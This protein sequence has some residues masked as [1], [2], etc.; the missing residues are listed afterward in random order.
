MEELEL[1]APSNIADYL[2]TMP[3]LV[4][5]ASTT[6]GNNA[7]S[8]GN[9]GMSLL[10]LR[11][12]GASRT[13]VL[14]DGRRHV[15]STL[16]GNVDANTLP[17]GLIE[18]VEVVTG[19]ASSVYGS[20]A[21]AGVV[22][23]KLN[24]DYVGT[25][26]FIQGG[27]SRYHDDN[28]VTTG[29]TLGRGFAQDRGHF[30]MD[31]EY[32]HS[33]GVENA[34]RRS[35]WKGWGTITNTDTLHSDNA[36][37]RIT[38][39]YENRA[40]EAPGGV[41]T[42]GPLKWTT[43]DPDGSPRLFDPGRL[44]RGGV[45]SSGGELDGHYA[46]MSLK[47][48]IERHNVFARG[49]FELTNA[50]EIFAEGTHAQSVVNTNSSYNYYNGNLTIHSDNPYLDPAVRDQMNAAGETSADYGLLLGVASPRVKVKTNRAV[51]GVN[52]RVGPDWKLDAYYEYGES[53]KSGQVLNTAN[54]DHLRLALDAVEDPATGRVVC[55]SSL[56]NP[57]NGCVPIN[58]FGGANIS[59]RAREYVMGT[60]WHQQTVTQKV[61]SVS[62]HGPAYTLPAGDMEVAFG[63]EHR[64]ESVRGGTDEASRNNEWTFGNF[65][66]SFGT[67][68][69]TEA[70]GE[71]LAPLLPDDKLSFNG[72]LRRTRY[73]YSGSV[74]TWKGGLVWRPVDALLVRGVRSR[75]IRAPNL[76]NLYE[77]GR[78]QRQNIE[79]PWFDNISRNLERVQT[80]NLD[81]K[82]EVAY[83][84]SI[85]LV[86]MAPGKSSFQGS[87][88]Y[89]DIK[90]HDAIT[91]LSNQ[92]IVDRC[93]EGDKSLCALV[94]RDDTGA[95]VGL[96][97]APINIAKR[98][99]KG[100]DIDMIYTSRLASGGSIDFRLKG[101]RLLKAIN[102][103][104]YSQIDYLGE[105]SSG[106]AKYRALGSATFRK[107]PLRLGATFRF[108]SKGVVDNSW[109]EGV[110]IDD[111]HVPSAWYL[112]L[113]GAYSFAN[114][115]LEAYARINNVLDRAP[116]RIASVGL[117]YS[118]KLYDGIGRYTSIGLRFR[119]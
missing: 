59:D 102:K 55:R 98:E 75:D 88:D 26:G 20:D 103:N 114:D 51:V 17:T 21:V 12:L 61:A 117:G 13:L 60:P 105:N 4:G 25:K 111:N 48:D 30:L 52:A 99:N 101:N 41:I 62:M 8:S 32:S 80:G 71:I 44:D 57:D 68:R 108:I 39:P 70:F 49:S 64:S 82:P 14:V 31:V 87:I 16:A 15:G 96:T 69:V 81:L 37:D 65:L 19:G 95:V 50:V 93:Y 22:N 18:S 67:N 56:E 73:S 76:A 5:S 83:T 40:T 66:P 106:R 45:R 7:I 115:R 107:G 23:F 100:V 116:P 9:T 91:T 77:A 89:Y 3:A 90:I 24:K 94:D 119:F 28:R 92:Q 78:T 74:T 53:K 118:G 36:P 97:R 86:F 46:P 109:I 110:D 43:F 27:Q 79:D 85:G 34:R 35:W 104:P 84:S 38:V 72:A 63:L 113:A 10:D 6:T 29:L 54:T 47:G 112:D 42:S 2:N 1:A 58:T 33:K 11:G